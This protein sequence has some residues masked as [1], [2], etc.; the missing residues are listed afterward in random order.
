MRTNIVH[1]GAGELT[2]EIR[3]IMQLV[4]TLSSMGMEITLENIGDPVAKGEEIPHWLK[5]IIADLAMENDS[6]AYSA[7]LGDL[8]TRKYLASLTNQI[9]GSIWTKRISS[10]LTAWGMPSPKYTASCVVRPA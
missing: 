6:Y 5:S 3:G 2:Y 7:T 1:L 10:S 4:E 8:E 9:A